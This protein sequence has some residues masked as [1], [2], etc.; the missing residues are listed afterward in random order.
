[1]EDFEEKPFPLFSA[2]DTFGRVQK[3]NKQFFIKNKF[4]LIEFWASWCLPCRELNAELT[5]KEKY[6]GT[7]GLRIVGFSLDN[8]IATWKAA[9][10]K[11]KV[12]WLQLSDLKATNSPLAIYFRLSQIPANIVVDNEGKIL[13]RNVFDKELDELLK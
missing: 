6:Y 7:K 4:T 13:A 12:I 10:S 9:I 5:K 2:V 8:D 11:D 3:L 1:V